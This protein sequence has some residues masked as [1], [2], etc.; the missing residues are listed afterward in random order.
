[1][2]HL[3]YVKSSAQRG[4][5]SRPGA[6]ITKASFSGTAVCVDYH[7]LWSAQQSCIRSLAVRMVVR[8]FIYVDGRA[9]EGA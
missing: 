2:I 9:L 1:M 4:H 5:T 6:A 3:L 8:V 7:R